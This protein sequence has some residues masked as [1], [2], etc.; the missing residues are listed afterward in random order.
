MKEK[1]KNEAKEQE[2]KKEAM[3]QKSKEV[4]IATIKKDLGV[5]MVVTSYQ[6]EPTIQIIFINGHPNDD[7]NNKLSVSISYEENY[8]VTSIG[9]DYLPQKTNI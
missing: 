4:A 9:Y 1:Q 5:E 8:L 2:Q 3:I 7:K 6:L